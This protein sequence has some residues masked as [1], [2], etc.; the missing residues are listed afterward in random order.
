MGYKCISAFRR[1][2]FH[3]TTGVA[4]V[5]ERYLTKPG[6][7]PS[8]QFYELP[9]LRPA[10]R[11]IG[12][13]EPRPV[14]VAP[15]PPVYFGNNSKQ[16]GIIPMLTLASGASTTPAGLPRRGPRSALGSVMSFAGSV[17]NVPMGLLLIAKQSVR[18]YAFHGPYD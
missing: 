16:Y 8:S 10:T 12:N 11:D 17:L 7:S 6:S 2:H 18:C 3:L 15:G 1:F 5:C 14:G 13:T 9:T 4:E